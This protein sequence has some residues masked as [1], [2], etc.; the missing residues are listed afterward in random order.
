[1]ATVEYIIEGIFQPIIGLV[2]PATPLNIYTLTGA[3]VFTAGLFVWLRLR[4]RHTGP[5]GFRQF[6]LARDIYAHPSATLDYRFYFV[7][8][9]IGAMVFAVMIASTAGWRD[10]AAEGFGGIFGPAASTTDPGWGVRIGVTVAVIVAFDL[11]YWFS[12][13][14]QHRVPALWEFHKV[15]HS[16]AVLTPATTW[17]QHPVEEVLV[18]N[19][20][21]APVGIVLGV[22]AWVFG[23][24]A[25]EIAL[26]KVNVLLLV[27]FATFFHLRHSHVWL[28]LTGLAGRILQ[29]PAHH[30][31]HHSDDPRHFNRNLGFCLSI[32]DWAF[33]TLY[34]PGRREELTFGLGAE[35][36]DYSSIRRL[37]AVPFVKLARR[38]RERGGVPAADPG[39]EP[40]SEPAVSG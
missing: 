28:P 40:R 9:A 25:T 37:Y 36:D 3:L 5:G 12:H 4:R 11:G 35:T 17:R 31:I 19:C 10:L 27:Y 7:N 15:H 23:P 1:M 14:L 29:S 30:Q 13:W 33:G 18:A 2:H 21:A 22:A 16:A 26:W 32:W 8:G 38:W 34:V 24:G 39:G 20:V 6:A